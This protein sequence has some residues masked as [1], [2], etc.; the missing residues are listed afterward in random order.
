MKKIICIVILSLLLLPVIACGGINTQGEAQIKLESYLTSTQFYNDLSNIEKN[1]VDS[2]KN[3][4]VDKYELEM[5]LK[6]AYEYYIYGSFVG[7][8][9][10]GEEIGIFDYWGV[11]WVWKTGRVSFEMRD[12]PVKR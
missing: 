6:N 10:S 3:I 2:V 4:K 1:G 8:D 5:P 9:S 12:Y 11:V 7:C